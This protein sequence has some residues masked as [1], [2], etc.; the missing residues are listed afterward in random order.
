MQP[1]RIE[2]VVIV[3]GEWGTIE[4]ITLTYVVIRVWDWRRLVVPITY[5][6]EKPF[7]NWTRNSSDLM[8]SV[9]LYLDFLVPLE[10]V[11]QETQRI[12]EESKL[13]DHRVFAFQVTDFKSNSVEVRILASAKTSP[14]LFDLRCEIREKIL[15]F[16]QDRYPSAFPQIKFALLH[17]AAE[18]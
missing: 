2:D 17:L 15:S 7:Q 6:L 9:F 10:K 1:M 8:G 18:P 4:E 13:W 3:E 12:V 16:L 5:F 11:R 14:E